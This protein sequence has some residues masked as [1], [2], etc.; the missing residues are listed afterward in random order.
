MNTDLTRRLAVFLFGCL[1]ALAAAQESAVTTSSGLWLVQTDSEKATRMLQLRWRSE[2]TD[3]ATR[4]DLFW[5]A[6]YKSQAGDQA[7]TEKDAFIISGSCCRM[8]V[9]DRSGEESDRLVSAI[10]HLYGAPMRPKRMVREE[11]FTAIA[12]HHGNLDFANEC[13]Q[14]KLFGKDGKPFDEHA[15]YESFF[16]VD[17]RNR[18][19]YWNEKDPDYREPLLR[20]LAAQ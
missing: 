16:N 6:E 10:G 9:T 17:L 5:F 3:S 18:L 19:A 1:P 12:L 7:M 2:P 14:L 4:E 11:S 15:Y 20:A 8:S 13:I